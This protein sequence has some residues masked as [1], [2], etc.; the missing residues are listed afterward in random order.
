MRLLIVLVCGILLMSRVCWAA[1][2]PTDLPSTDST[3]DEVVSPPATESPQNEARGQVGNGFIL[4][5]K[6]CP[7]DYLEQTD[8]DEFLNFVDHGGKWVFAN[9]YHDKN[10]KQ[11]YIAFEGDVGFMSGLVSGAQPV[12]GGEIDCLPGKPS[13]KAYHNHLGL[14]T[15]SSKEQMHYSTLYDC[16]MPFSLFYNEGQAF[17]ATSRQNIRFLGQPASH[18]CTRLNPK[19][20]PKLFKW[21]GKDEIRVLICRDKEFGKPQVKQ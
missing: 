9:F 13:P 15:V 20:A 19:E 4:L 10:A 7:F 5:P 6:E 18:G 8:W 3:Q 12:K 14:F 17:H 11:F 16:N 21:V 2:I 1:D